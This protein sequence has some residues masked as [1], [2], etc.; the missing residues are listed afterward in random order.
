MPSRLRRHDEFGQVHFLTI[1]CFRRLQ[2]FRHDAVKLSFIRAMEVTRGKHGVRWL[3]YVVMPE[4][5]H[6]LALP[7]RLGS[8]QVTPISVVLH[9][10]KQRSGHAGKEALR[11]AWREH[12]SLG[13]KPLD[14]WA[15]GIGPKPFWKP[16][17][18]DFNVVAE[19]KV[20]EKLEYMHRNPVTRGLVERPEQW[21]WS[22]YRFYELGDESLIRMDWDGV[23]PLKL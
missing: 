10:L 5:V 22:S 18:Y 4:H 19:Q 11:E 12:R 1:S 17:A 7:Q 9:D 21:R 14:A 23:L 13:T 8:D 16:R 2:F 3:G 6:V 20:S 15:T